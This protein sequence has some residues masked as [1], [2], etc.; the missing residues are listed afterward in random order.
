MS[1]ANAWSGSTPWP[2]W[3]RPD[4]R[5]ALHHIPRPVPRAAHVREETFYDQ[6]G[7][8]VFTTNRGLPGVGLTR[9]EFE[10]IK[11]AQP[12]DTL[13]DYAQQYVA[14]FDRCDREADMTQA[15][16]EF[17]AVFLQV[18]RRILSSDIA[19]STVQSMGEKALRFVGRR[20]QGT[21]W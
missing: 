13:P 4:H 3:P 7:L 20:R 19:R 12:G 6:R 18:P 2:P 14:P 11:N 21:L 17:S 1:A 16:Q 5:R 9:A 10:P 15:Y 8:I